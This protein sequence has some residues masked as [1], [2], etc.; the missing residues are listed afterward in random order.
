MTTKSEI[1]L[2]RVLVAATQ[3]ISPLLL[4]NAPQQFPTMCKKYCGAWEGLRDRKEVKR[5][6]P[7]S[8]VEVGGCPE[9]R[10]CSNEIQKRILAKRKEHKK[11]KICKTGEKSITEL[12]AAKFGALL[13]HVQLAATAL[14]I[15]EPQAA[16]KKVT[17]DKLG[18]VAGIA[19]TATASGGKFDKK[20]AG[21]KPQQH[22]GKYRKFLPVVEGTGIRSQERE[23]T[24]KILNK[25][26]S[27]NSHDILNI[28]KHSIANYTISSSLLFFVF[29]GRERDRDTVSSLCSTSKFSS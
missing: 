2:L 16:P 26:I 24:E 8:W 12:E 28:E 19:A 20:L 13:S 17:K 18:N 23:Q 10:N 25:I 11:K 15:T 29:S 6:V 4:R 14:P 7:H 21:E 3:R 9:N 1:P 5:M 22:Q 27:K